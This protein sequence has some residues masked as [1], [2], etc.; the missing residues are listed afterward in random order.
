MGATLRYAKVIDVNRFTEQGSE[1]RPGLSCEV[2]LTGTAPA[3]A[4]PFLIVRAWEEAHAFTENWRI[5]D[6]HGRTL[7]EGTTREVLHE[8]QDIADEIRDLTFE[9]ADE[10]YAVVFEVEEREVARVS[11][12]VLEPSP[13]EQGRMTET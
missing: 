3:M 5:V 11:F 9:Y 7:R 8:H 13:A 10:G 2:R 12:M 4:E 6:P 1:L